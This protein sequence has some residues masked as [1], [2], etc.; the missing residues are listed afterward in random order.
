M[1]AGGARAQ[2]GWEY[3]LSVYGWFT[4]LSSEVDTR[5]GQVDADLTFGDIWEDLDM[6]A[7]AAFEAR[8]GRWALVTDL[9]YS[10]ISA[11][12][13]APADLPFEDVEVETEL[14][15]LSALAAYSV[16]DRTDLRVDLAGGLR[17]Y[18]VALDVDLNAAA[19]AD[20][21]ATSFGDDWI[22]AVVGAR[23]HAPIS[24]FWYI[25]GFADLGGFGIG[26]SSDLSGQIYA[27]VGYRFNETWQI[28]GGYRY[29]SIDREI[30]GND[31]ELELFGPLVGV[32]ARF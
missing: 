29:L 3:S 21:R 32:T 1:L 28:E 13:G 18:D 12:E 5:F 26:D 10:R 24:E 9:N 14:T 31:T 20:D 7:F 11:E 25:T 23:V 22:D 27:G 2:S 4:G 15:I 19:S 6:A 30:D 16:I 17:Y 8:S